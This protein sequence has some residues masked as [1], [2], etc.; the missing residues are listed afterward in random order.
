MKLTPLPV[1]S[2]C[3]RR[4]IIGPYQPGHQGSLG[5]Y[6]TRCECG[7]ETTVTRDGLRRYPTC[8]KCPLRLRPEDAPVGQRFGRLTVTRFAEMII[9]S[10]G[11]Q[12]MKVMTTCD[13]GTEHLILLR[14]LTIGQ[15]RSCGCWTRERVSNRKGAHHFQGTRLHDIWIGMRGRCRNVNNTAYA[16]YGGRGISVTPEWEDYLTFHAWATTHGYTDELTIDRI[17]PDGN[18]E[19]ANCR[20]LTRADNSRRAR[21]RGSVA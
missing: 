5:R 19:P 6:P 7:T 15:S 1:G 3:G 9:D 16:R 12:Q 11:R 18:Y 14:S 13:C 8:R 4:T 10:V 21:P 2:V 20:W 17:D